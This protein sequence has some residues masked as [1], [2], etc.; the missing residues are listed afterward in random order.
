M[1]LSCTHGHPCL[2]T[3]YAG[4]VNP[5]STDPS[6]PCDVHELAHC[7][8]CHPPARQYRRGHAGLDVP[9]GH[10]VEV[11]GGKGVYHHPDCFNVT[12]EWEGADLAVLGERLVRSPEQI[13][14]LGLRPAQC[15]EPPAMT[16][17]R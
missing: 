9:P 13:R 6:V 17:P 10:Y 16:A 1:I 3:A 15:C 8:L 4:T 7:A 14:D 5:A 11:R 2:R 12:G